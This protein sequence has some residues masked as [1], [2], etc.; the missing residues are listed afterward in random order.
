MNCKT[1]CDCSSLLYFWKALSRR[2]KLVLVVFH[3]IRDMT[4]YHYS[5]A[6]VMLSVCPGCSLILLELTSR[7]CCSACF[8]FQLLPYYVS[9]EISDWNIWKNLAASKGP[10]TIESPERG[11]SWCC[12]A[13]QDL[14]GDTSQGGCLSE[15][16]MGCL[17]LSIWG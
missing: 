6:E 11:D 15:R 16:A 2:R 14:G 3:P 17:P 1:K 7:A 10:L 5:I 8:L 9:L 4:F 12:G 13:G